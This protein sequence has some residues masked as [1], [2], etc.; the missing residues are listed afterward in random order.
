LAAQPNPEVAMVPL[1]SLWI[2][3]LVSAVFAFVASSVIHMMLGYHDSDHAKL[4]LESDVL[5]ALR[6]FNIPPGDYTMPH[7]T[8]MSAMKNPE[9]VEKMNK[10]PV[11]MMTVMRNGMVEMGPMMVAWFVFCVVVSVFAAYI[12][13]H[14]LQ[15]GATYLEVFRY[16]G[17]TAFMGYALAL[18]QESIWF[19]RKLSTTIKNTF[20]GLVY[21]MLTAG[22]FGWLW[23]R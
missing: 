10:G 1:M 8:G 13:S 20:D 11:V 22:V 16:V 7:A 23:P 12:A 21:A 15:Q 18:W 5:D 19:K 9:Y 6:K 17:A 2:P 14:A 3:I 4:P